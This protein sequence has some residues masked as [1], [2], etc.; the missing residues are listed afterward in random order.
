MLPAANVQDLH[1]SPEEFRV[2][3]FKDGDSIFYLN[4]S[5]AQDFKIQE[6]EKGRSFD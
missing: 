2:A 6:R 4:M 1:G 5:T 3:L